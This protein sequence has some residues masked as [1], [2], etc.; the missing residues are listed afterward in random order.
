MQ[1]QLGL[2]PL[3]P[4]LNEGNILGILALVIGIQGMQKGVLKLKSRNL[5]FDSGEGRYVGD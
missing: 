1:I 3:W 5:L 2:A 4:E